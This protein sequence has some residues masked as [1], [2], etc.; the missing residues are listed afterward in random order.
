VQPNRRSG[1]NPASKPFDPVTAPSRRMATIRRNQVV[2]PPAQQVP[3]VNCSEVVNK[4][5][6]VSFNQRSAPQVAN[7]PRNQAPSRA[8]SQFSRSS[9]RPAELDVPQR[10]NFSGSYNNYGPQSYNKYAPQQMQAQNGSGR[11]DNLGLPEEWIY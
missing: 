9:G 5:P 11:I 7:P 1:P 4:I 3:V 2:N 8:P 6:I 10:R